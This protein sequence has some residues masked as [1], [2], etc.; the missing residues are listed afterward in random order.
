LKVNTIVAQAGRPSKRRTVASDRLL[1]RHPKLNDQS[2]IKAAGLL[3]AGKLLYMRTFEC[4]LFR[5]MRFEQNR[6]VGSAQNALQ[7]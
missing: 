7:P 3:G 2:A 6:V 5:R 4:I 1:D